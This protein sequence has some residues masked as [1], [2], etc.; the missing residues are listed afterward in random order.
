[1]CS[2]W[3]VYEHVS[4][5]GKI[6]VGI[7]NQ[8]VKRRWKNGLGYANSNYFFGAIIK[9]GWINFKHIIIAAGLGE[10]TAKN[11]EKDLIAFNKAKGISYNI[12]DGGDGV[13]GVYYSERHREQISISLKSFYSK[14]GHPQRGF[15]HSESSKKKMS[16][17]QKN[18]WTPEYRDRQRRNHNKPIVAINA[19]GNR[20]DFE[21]TL[22]AS[23]ELKVPTTSIWRHL[24]SG[25]PYKG[26]IFYYLQEY[27][28][29]Q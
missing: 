12:T 20:T 2:N 18:L 7:T 25:K 3:I 23:R 11:M 9:Y 6:Y 14:H 19:D 8:P 10:K 15:K 17:A 16:E 22:V 29:L 27:I 26:Y 28:K 5:S 21:S 13:T 24:K 4:P 1:M